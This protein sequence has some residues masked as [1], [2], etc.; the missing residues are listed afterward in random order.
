MQPNGQLHN[1]VALTTGNEQLAPTGQKARAVAQPD[2][3]P[4]VKKGPNMYP[5]R[6]SKRK[7]FGYPP[8]SLVNIRTEL[9]S[10]ALTFF[11]FAVALR[12]NPGHSPLI[13]EGF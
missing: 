11:L 7:F 13:L 10:I 3:T 9:Y 2:W 4:R 1:H 8:R 5:Y 6:K 12:P